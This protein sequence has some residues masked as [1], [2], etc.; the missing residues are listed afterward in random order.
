MKKLFLFSCLAILLSIFIIPINHALAGE[1]AYQLGSRVVTGVFIPDKPAEPSYFTYKL[2]SKGQGYMTIKKGDLSA[3]INFDAPSE[4]AITAFNKISQ[5][6]G[7]PYQVI[8][9]C[10]DGTLYLEQR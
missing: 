2:R 5:Q 7:F 6:I 1:E 8:Y 9:N 3:K 4:K 10:L